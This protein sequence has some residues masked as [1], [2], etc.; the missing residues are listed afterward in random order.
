MLDNYTYFYDFV[1]EDLWVKAYNN[2]DHDFWYIKIHEIP[3]DGGKME[4]NA[5]EY[6]YIEGKWEFDEYELY[7]L[8]CIL[9]HPTYASSVCRDWAHNWNIVI[10]TD[11][12]TTEEILDILHSYG[13]IDSYEDEE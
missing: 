9:K 3:S 6:E 10:P 12:L 8:E 1:G 5:I 7:D 2:E 4:Y 13:T 11:I